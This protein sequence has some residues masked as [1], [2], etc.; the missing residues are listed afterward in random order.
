VAIATAWDRVADRL[1]ALNYYERLRPTVT[2]MLALVAELRQDPGLED[3]EPSVS[4]A[5]LNLK[6]VH[7]RRYVMVSRVEDEPRFTV[8][9]VDPQ[10]DFHETRTV[11]EDQAVT[12]IA[13]YIDRLRS[14]I[15]R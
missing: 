11:N 8:S 15:A 4:L 1:R 13:D 9:F 10:L 14:G 7:S 6:L 5:A 2:A 12:T 3:V